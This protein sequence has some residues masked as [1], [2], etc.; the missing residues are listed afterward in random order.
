MTEPKILPKDSKANIYKCPYEVENCAIHK[1]CHGIE[2]PEKL[3]P[4]FKAI[5][6]RPMR[7]AKIEVPLMLVT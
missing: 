1:H 2:V 3:P 4:G 6:P 7:K 5:I